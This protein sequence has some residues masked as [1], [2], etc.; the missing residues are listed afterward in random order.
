MRPEIQRARELRRNMSEPEIMLWSRL[1]RLR[2]R[3]FHIRRQ[4][5]FRGYYLDFACHARRLVIEVD[6]FQHGDDAQ[7]AHDAVRDRILARQG[8]RVLRFW[9]GEVRGN[10]G[11]V[12]DQ[13]VLALEGAPR[14]RI[15]TQSPISELERDRPTLT[16]S[17]SVPPH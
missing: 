15:E 1:R 2:D 6:G 12:M 9:A 8:Y 13:I 3:G 7:A 14:T 11:G 4:V 5:P 17:R 16:A 10:L